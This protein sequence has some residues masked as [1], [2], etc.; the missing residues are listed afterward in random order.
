[1]ASNNHNLQSA[2]ESFWVANCEEDRDSDARVLR[3]VTTL[4]NPLLQELYKRDPLLNFNPLNSST[5]HQGRTRYIYE[6]FLCLKDFKTSEDELSIEDG[7]SPTGFAFAKL[8]NKKSPTDEL[9]ITSNSGKK[10]LSPKTIS[11]KILHHLRA[12]LSEDYILASRSSEFQF[13]LLDHLE[14]SAVTLKLY[15]PRETFK[16]HILPTIPCKGRW[17]FGANAWLSE[18]SHWPTKG[19]KYE[20]IDR[21]IHLVGRSAPTKSPCQWQIAF[22]EPMKIMVDSSNQCHRNKCLDVMRLIVNRSQIL[23]KGMTLFALETATLKL[24]KMYPQA[25]FWREEKFAQRFIDLVEELRK[26]VR[27]RKLNDFF[28]YDLNL[29]KDMDQKTSELCDQE[30]KKLLEDPKQFFIDLKPLGGSCLDTHL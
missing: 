25:I 21:G 30:L 3:F 5:T 26:A 19:M 12:L 9:C 20:S 2:L 24:Y 29:L 18:E 10:Y 15:S 4:L 17:T 27:A 13:D 14:D 23:Q 8:S 28:L 6:G 16:L 7:N 11:E 22:F 1:M